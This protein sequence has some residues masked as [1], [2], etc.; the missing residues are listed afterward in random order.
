MLFFSDEAKPAVVI[1]HFGQ[2]VW[3]NSAGPAQTASRG[4][5]FFTVCILSAPV[6]GI[7][8]W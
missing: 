7:T 3:A 8:L 5:R 2:I 1:V 4:S 6:G